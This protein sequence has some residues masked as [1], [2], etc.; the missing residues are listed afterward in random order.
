LNESFCF[1]HSSSFLIKLG[2]GSHNEMS[3]GNR[4]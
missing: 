1:A 2:H 3:Y 4:L